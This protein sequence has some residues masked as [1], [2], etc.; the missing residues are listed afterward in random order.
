[1][2]VV[3]WAVSMAVAMAV[4]MVGTDMAATTHLA[5]E[6]TGSMGFTEKLLEKLSQL[7]HLGPLNL[8]S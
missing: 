8:P 6:D 3:A 1:M 4:A 5:A 2:A 7:V